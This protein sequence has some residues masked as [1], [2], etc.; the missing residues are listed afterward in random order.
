MAERQ[1]YMHTTENIV[2][3]KI[4]RNYEK[5]GSAKYSRIRSAPSAQ[6]KFSVSIFANAD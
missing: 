5:A 4:S 6:T 1:I 3:V 2:Y